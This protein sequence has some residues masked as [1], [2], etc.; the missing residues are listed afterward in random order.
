MTKFFYETFEA[1]FIVEKYTVA[2]HCVLSTIFAGCVATN[3]AAHSS[4]L[5]REEMK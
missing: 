2:C 1:I 3:F 5:D 4:S